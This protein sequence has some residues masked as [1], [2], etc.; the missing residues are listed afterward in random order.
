VSSDDLEGLA[1]LRDHLER[2]GYRCG[3][4]GYDVT[5]FRRM[6]AQALSSV[7][8]DATRATGYSGS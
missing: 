7:Q 5:Y 1:L 3:Q 4:Y 2:N 8:V 6:L